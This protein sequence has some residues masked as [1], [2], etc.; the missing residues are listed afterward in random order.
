MSNVNCNTPQDAEKLRGGYYTSPELA[1]WLCRWAI[2]NPTERVLEP[3][4]GDGVFLEAA[5]GRFESIGLD[6]QLSIANRIKGI[7]VNP[8]EAEKARHRLGQ[9]LGLCRGDIVH[10]GDFFTWWREENDE[11]FDVVVGNPPFI[12]YRNFPED[13]RSVAMD[14]L[15]Q[16]GLKANRL[17][18]IW[19]PFVVAAAQSL[20]EGGR[21]AFVLPA[22]LLQ[23]AYANQLRG[24]LVSKFSRID[25]ITCNQLLFQKAEQEIVLILAEGARATP[26]TGDDCRVAM[27]EFDTVTEI[28]E[29]SPY[30]VLANTQPKTVR[31]ESEKWLKYLL[32]P[33]E[34]DLMRELRQSPAITN[35]GSHASVDVGV[36]TGKNDFFVMGRERLTELELAEFAV[37]LIS[38]SRQLQGASIEC[39]D[40][41][42]LDASGERVHLLHLASINGSTLS[43]PLSK[44]IKMGED[45]EVDRGYKCSNRTPWYAVPSVWEPDGFLL[46][47][48][49]D[50]PR[51]VLNSAGA[52]CTDT[53]HR[54]NCT[55]EPEK[56]ITNTYTF[57][58]GASAEIEGRSYGGGIL[59]L[60]PTEAERLLV[61]AQLTE[62]MT[63]G[64]CDELVRAGRLRELLQENSVRVL[65]NGVGLSR[66]DCD[67]LQEIWNKMGKRRRGRGLR[68]TPGAVNAT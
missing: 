13:Y 62:A 39:R 27:T 10:S 67:T 64:E 63:I 3:S 4:C 12:R 2:R 52:T 18:N 35:L 19:V 51:I 26:Y 32:T 22:E 49:Y 53:I 29:R 60:E 43:E 41:V 54:L 65:V 59:A 14:L 23:V 21:L 16:M 31:H 58:T 30:S 33:V 20:K 28:V 17:T 56:I 9:S 57:L 48:I 42:N 34:I 8:Q 44:Y 37:P 11:E 66:R 47:Q 38:R 50:F 7:E 6:S 36:V 5:I 68:R 46:R 55:D 61:P 24:F 1:A 40:W 25:I 45:E 15:T